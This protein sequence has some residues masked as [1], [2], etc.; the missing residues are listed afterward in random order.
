MSG[1]DVVHEVRSHN[2]HPVFIF[3]TAFNQY[4]IKAIKD[5]V[6]DYILKPIDIDDLKEAIERYKDQLRRTTAFTKASAVERDEGRPL[7]PRL[8]RLKG[9]KWED[10]G[11]KVILSDR[12][13]EVLKLM[14]HGKTSKEIADALFISKTT[15]D[16]HRRN[17]LEKTGARNSTELISLALEK[18]WV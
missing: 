7:S 16:T 1:F 4:A 13:K 6:F 18:G 5:T 8:R 15:V 3:V 2:C 9:T 12:E 10:A 14:M 11:L 17:I